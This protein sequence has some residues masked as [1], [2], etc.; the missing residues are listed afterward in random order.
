[1]KL[2][3]TIRIEPN[4]LHAARRRAVEENRS[5]TNFVETA[6]KTRI[7]EGQRGCLP[8]TTEEAE[9]SGAATASGRNTRQSSRHK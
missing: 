4:L 2:P 7:S 9:T 1:M 3:L 6:L 8:P 5:L